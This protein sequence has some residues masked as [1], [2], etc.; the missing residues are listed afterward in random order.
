M[1]STI[2]SEADFTS[3]SSE[4]TKRS[5][6]LDIIVEEILKKFQ[7]ALNIDQIY[8]LPQAQ[9]QYRAYVFFEESLKSEKSCLNSGFVEFVTSTLKQYKGK[10]AQIFFEFDSKEN[11]DKNFGNYQNRMR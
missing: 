1:S 7:S 2:P 4:Q 6:Y 9:D 10:Q 3:A 11:V 8:I 5:K